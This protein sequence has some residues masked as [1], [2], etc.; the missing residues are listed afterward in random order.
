MIEDKHHYIPRLLL[1]SLK[2][3]LETAAICGILTSIFLT[4]YALI[5]LPTHLTS[6]LLNLASTSKFTLL[7]YPVM[8]VIAYIFFTWLARSYSP[9]SPFHWLWPKSERNIQ[10]TREGIHWFKL[11]GIWG[12]VCI[13]WLSLRLVQDQSTLP[14]F[15]IFTGILLFLILLGVVAYPYY[16]SA[17]GARMH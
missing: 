5:A 11:L 9:H 16:R 7:Y 12:Q 17:S 8:L 14:G 10:L 2:R 1:F 6:D 4:T 3:P 13:E 15:F